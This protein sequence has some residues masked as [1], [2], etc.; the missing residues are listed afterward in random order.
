MIGYIVRRLVQLLPVLLVASIGIWGMIYAVPGGP[1]ARETY[2]ALKALRSLLP[3]EERL[4][5][6]AG[7]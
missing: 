3:R 1:V 4:L 6:A 5:A 2:Q 7:A